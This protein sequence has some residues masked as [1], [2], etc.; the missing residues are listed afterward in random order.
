MPFAIIAVVV[1]AAVGAGLFFLSNPSAEMPG[2][3]STEVATRPTD[4][5]EDT[6]LP[7]VTTNESTD[8]TGNTNTSIETVSDTETMADTN[9]SEDTNIYIDGTYSASASYLTPRRT[10]HLVGVTLTIENDV[11]VDSI[12]TFD[13]EANTYANDNQ[14]RF[15]RA[16]GEQVIG[17]P[18]DTI[19]LSR[20]GGASLTSGAWN[21][22]KIKIAAEARS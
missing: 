22:A 7:P 16:Y 4:E 13:G 20:V 21:E 12:V 6:T 8:D 19:S 1:I 10:E 9:E 17:Q 15:D 3:P 18:L 2:E 11:V 5:T 14:A